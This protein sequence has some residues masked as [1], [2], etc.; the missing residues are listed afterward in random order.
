MSASHTTVLSLA[1]DVVLRFPSAGEILIERGLQRV[2]VGGH[3]VAIVDAFRAP[4]MVGEVI[5]RLSTRAAGMR[6]FLEIVATVNELAHV[7]ILVESSAIPAVLNPDATRFDAAHIHLEMLNDRVRTE[8]YLRAIR[9]TVRPGDVVLDIGTGSGVLAVAA[10]KAGASRV[11]AIELSGIAAGAER[12]FEANGVAE[13]V[14]LLRGE[15][16]ALELPVRADVLVAELIGIDPLGESILETTRDAVARLLVPGA[17][18]IPASI[19]VFAIPVTL[20]EAVTKRWQF[21][22]SSVTQWREWYDIDFSPLIAL[23]AQSVVA[24]SAS[25]RQLSAWEPLAA[26]ISCFVQELS[27]IDRTTVEVLRPVTVTR[28]GRIDAVALYFTVQLS[29]GIALSTDPTEPRDD[30]HWRHRVWLLPAPM[31]VRAGDALELAF[32]HRASG[33]P[34]ELRRAGE[35]RVEDANT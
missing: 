21:T 18:L 19:E 33:A 25:P 2:V 12:V 24:T 4:S 20:P 28:A 13:R 8:K 22:Q 3:G 30:N 16:T 1:P 27:A 11:F 9:E 29:E 31:E 35:H 23:S 15:S 10:A 26:P 14:S 17:R 7:G 32:R 34:V 5:D 6:D